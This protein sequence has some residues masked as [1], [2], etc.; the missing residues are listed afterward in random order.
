MFHLQVKGV[1]RYWLNTMIKL[2]KLLPAAE[3]GVKAKPDVCLCCA[4][5]AVLATPVAAMLFLL[6]PSLNGV[7]YPSWAASCLLVGEFPVIV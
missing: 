1:D 4:T 7:G 2:M 6:L 5:V 3:P